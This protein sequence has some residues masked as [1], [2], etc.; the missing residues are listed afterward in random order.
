M[1]PTL[2]IMAAGMGSRYGGLKQVDP[3]GPNGE[4]VLD[5]SVYDAIR[6]GFGKVVFIIRRDIEKPFKEHIGDKLA[7]KIPVEYVFQSLE[8][9]P[10]PYAVPEGREKPW[11]TGQAVLCCREVV[12]EPFAVINADDYYGRQ[13]FEL[14][15]EELGGMD[16]ESG[17]SCMV[18]FRIRNTLSPNGPVTRGVCEVEDGFL[19]RV[20]ETFK[21]EEDEQGRVHSTEEGQ[22]RELSGDEIASMNMWGFTPQIFTVLED[23]FKTFLGEHGQEMKSE[24]LI[25][26]VVDEMIREGLTR[27]KVM[28]SEDE[29]FGVTYPED[30][31]TVQK[32]IAQLVDEGRYPS[33]LWS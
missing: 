11:G 7:E 31:P 9:L 20:V 17:D 4:I 5:Y 12:S 8:D 10:D 27:V 24:Y 26:T 28:R 19:R 6:A 1:K 15:A 13:G 14:L 18:G 23:K 21:I 22:V 3:M 2:V 16:P 32:E 30:K 33:P 25:P 29:W